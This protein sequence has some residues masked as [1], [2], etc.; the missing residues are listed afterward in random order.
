MNKTLVDQAYVVFYVLCVLHPTHQATTAAF[1]RWQRRL[2][3]YEAVHE[4]PWGYGRALRLGR[5]RVLK[6]QDG[7]SI[8]PCLVILIEC[9]KLN[10]RTASIV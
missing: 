1:R 10:Y 5:E 9:A 8:D 4:R 2:A 6:M 3:A 7:D